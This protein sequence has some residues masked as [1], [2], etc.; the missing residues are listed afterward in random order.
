[1]W[2]CFVTCKIV[3]LETVY[4]HACWVKEHVSNVNQRGDRV[5]TTAAPECM[6]M[7]MCW[8]HVWYDE[9]M[10]SSGASLATGGEDV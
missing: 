4:V 9:L 2:Y 8:V 1:M 3:I 7:H 10:I 6:G 5:V